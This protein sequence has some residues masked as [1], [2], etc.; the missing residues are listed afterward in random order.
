MKSEGKPP[1]PTALANALQALDAEAIYGEHAREYEV[2]TRIA[3]SNGVV[4]LDLANETWQAVQV[5]KDGWQVLNTPPVRFRRPAGMGKLPFPASDGSIQS[6]RRFANVSDEEWPLLVG[7]LVGAFR[8]KGPYAVLELH[9]EQG[10]AKSTLCKVLRK[11]IDPNTS[12]LRAKPK[13]DRDLMIAASNGWIV[14]LDNPSGLSDSLSDALCR[15]S[16]GGGFGTRKLYADDQEVLFNAARPIL[17][18]GIQDIATRSDLLDRALILTLKPI[19]K[20]QRRDEDEF[21]TDFDK[22]YP[23]ILGGLLHAVKTAIRHWSDTK[24][25]NPPRMANFTRWVVAAEPALPWDGGGFVRAYDI[26]RAR[27]DEKVIALNATAMLVAEMVQDGGCWRGTPTDLLET[28]RILAGSRPMDLPKAANTL[29]AELSRISPNLRGIGIE[30]EL[31]LRKGHDSKRLI[32]IRKNKR[33]E[34]VLL[35]ARN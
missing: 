15:L 16:T 5:T 3:E 1:Q 19:S 8:P 24:L 6:L 4:Y 12:E 32:A 35:A 30:V 21:W 27:A 33:D 29:S 10:T 34:S 26:N 2:Y 13:E 11:L 31:G 18:N 7:W 17:L 14:A 20:D 28:L 22:E 25:A 23:T 9:G